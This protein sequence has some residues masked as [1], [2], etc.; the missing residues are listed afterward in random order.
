MTKGPGGNNSSGQQARGGGSKGGGGGSSKGGG[1]GSS[2]GGGGGSS[3]SSR[4]QWDCM[5][6]P[7]Q[8][9]YIERIG[10]LEIVEKCKMSSNTSGSLKGGGSGS[11]KGGGSKGGGGGGSMS[12]RAQW[13]CMKAPGQSG[14]IERIGPL[15]IVEK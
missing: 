1:S 5:K 10:P 8:S 4:A 14:Y 15:E 13:D 12:S 6:A 3:M 7:G 11:S 2:K 9:G